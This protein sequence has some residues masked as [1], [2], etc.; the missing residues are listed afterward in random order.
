MGWSMHH[1]VG[2]IHY[3]PAPCYRGYTLITTR[4]GFDANLLD[5]E[6][7]I[8]HRWHRPEGINYAVLLP[9]GNLLLRTHPAADAGGAEKIGGSSAALL[10]LD[11]DSTVVWAYRNPMLHHDF[12]RLPNGNTLTLLFEAIPDELASRVQGGYASPDDSPTMYGDTV[13]EI[14]PSGEVVYQWRA[15]EH[16]HPEEDVICPLEAR[17]EWT[18]GNSLKVTSQ[19]D[20][21]VSY[22]LTS[23]V[24]IVDRASGQFRW[25]WGPGVLSHQHNPTWLDNGRVLIFDNGGHRRGSSY[26]RVVEVDPASN[27]IAWEYQGSPPVSFFSEVISGAER[28]PNGN[29]LICE[30]VPGRIFEVTPNREIVWEYISPFFVTNPP[31]AGG[32]VFG[33]AN[34]TF[35]AHRYGPDYPGLWDRD[36]DPARFANI[37]RLYA[38]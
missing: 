13:Q 23:T 3:S 8:C 32:T 16:L 21:L 14:T 20:L 5:M 15:W 19:G 26:S 12:E 36:L 1:P 24:G 11:W 31:T 9:S 35:R 17:K 6:G 22:R 7:R 30:G 37:N 27:E 25:K 18:H 4:G 33:R 2:L 34:A 29:T 28:L 38:G 10:E